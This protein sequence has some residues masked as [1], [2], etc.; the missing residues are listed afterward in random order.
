MVPL[1]HLHEVDEHATVHVDVLELVVAE[2]RGG[3]VLDHVLGR[4]GV[5]ATKA[6]EGPDAAAEELGGSLIE[7]GEIKAKDVVPQDDVG[8]AASDQALPCEEHLFLV[9]KDV[10]VRPLELG[11]GAQ[12]E[13]DTPAARRASSAVHTV[14]SP[15]LYDG[16]PPHGPPAL[17]GV[18]ET[19]EE[20][21][22]L[23]LQE[24][25]VDIFRDVED[26]ALESRLVLAR[27]QGRLELHADALLY[28]VR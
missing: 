17:K 10:H 25:A 8:V 27:R 2:R 9:L 16:V 11:A 23:L 12:G 18:V 22:V 14:R 13:D 7:V 26:D 6:L 19:L 24:R 3:Q 1:H 15:D 4:E 21:C 20:H 28:D 5:E